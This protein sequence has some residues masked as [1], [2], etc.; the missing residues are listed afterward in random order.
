MGAAIG[1]V[2]V[3]EAN[4]KPKGQH[5][6]TRAGAGRKRKFSFSFMFEVG[7]KCESLFKAAQDEVQAQSDEYRYTVVSDIRSVWARSDAIAVPNRKAW[8]GSEKFEEY[9]ADVEEERET[10][11]K[12]LG[13][14][15]NNK[16][17]MQRSMAHGPDGANPSPQKPR[18]PRGTRK[19]IIQQVAAQYNLAEKQVDNLWQQ[20][21]RFEAE[22]EAEM[23]SERYKLPKLDF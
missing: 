4:D 12:G 22:A 7:A 2:V 10:I 20:K 14:A 9:K 19:R 23:P 3:R 5:G 15:S 18:A 1:C 16:R 13:S 21:R 11:R 8:L 17:E 6:G